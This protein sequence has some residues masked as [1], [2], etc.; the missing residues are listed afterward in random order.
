[1]SLIKRW[2]YLQSY[3]ATIQYK[4]MHSFWQARKSGYTKY[5]QSLMNIRQEQTRCLNSLTEVSINDE[6]LSIPYD[7]HKT[8]ARLCDKYIVINDR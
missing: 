8:G 2:R 4:E 5:D 3:K 1:M 6:Q 7:R